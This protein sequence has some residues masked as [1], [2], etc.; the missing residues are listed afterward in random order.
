MTSPVLF[1]AAVAEQ[2]M[3]IRFGPT[4]YVVLLY[5]SPRSIEETASLD[6]MSLGRFELGDV[7]GIARY[8]AAPRLRTLV[9]V[10]ET[11]DTALGKAP[12]HVLE[13]LFRFSKA[14]KRAGQE[15]TPKLG[16]VDPT[17]LNRQKAVTAIREGVE[18]SGRTVI[19][20]RAGGSGPTGRTR[21]DDRERPHSRVHPYRNSGRE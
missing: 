4:R 21:R 9:Y 10:D 18:T 6:A 7:P 3:R 14:A 15:D 12:P 8:G 17:A 16:A 1:A 5:P 20:T 2:T 19:F 11:A 13:A